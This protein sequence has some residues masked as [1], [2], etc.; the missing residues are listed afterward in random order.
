MNSWQEVAPAFG[1]VGLG[2]GFIGLAL[3]SWPGAGSSPHLHPPPCTSQS[4]RLLSG[5]TLSHVALSPGALSSSGVGQLPG[6]NLLWKELGAGI[7]Q[8]RGH[9]CLQTSACG[10]VCVWGQGRL[11]GVAS[12]ALDY[13]WCLYGHRQEEDWAKALGKRSKSLPPPWSPADQPFP[14]WHVQWVVPFTKGLPPVSLH[15]V[16]PW[17]V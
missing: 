14:C 5:H 2:G 6:P 1:V 17:K 15:P 11:C 7:R 10:G 16:P 8:R 12:P 4:G 3:G 9:S 13:M